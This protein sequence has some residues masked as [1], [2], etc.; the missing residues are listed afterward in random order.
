MG[1]NNETTTKFKADISNLKAGITQA[2]S[3][4]KSANAE[5]KNATAGMNNW[6]KSADGL[7]AKITQLDKTFS[8]Q[9]EIVKNLKKQYQLVCQQE[10]E[11]SASAQQLADKINNA[12][13]KLKNTE[14]QL[15]KYKDALAK[16]QTP[17]AELTT[18]IDT[19]AKNLENLK[20][21]YADVVIKEGENSESAKDLAGKI[22]SLSGELKENKEKLQDAKTKAEELDQSFDNA[23]DAA[24]ESAQ[25]SKDAA[26][27]GYTTMKDVLAD[28]ASTAIKE[29]IGGFKDMVSAA[30][31]AYS[32]TDAAVDVIVRKTGATGDALTEYKD[33]YNKVMS[34]VK[35]D[36]EDAGAAVGEIATRFKITDTDKLAA[37]SEAFIKFADIN[38]L[39]V[40]TA[41]IDVAKAMKSANVKTENYSDML[42]L[43]TK[44]GQETGISV[45]TLT[46]QIITNGATLRK[47]GF[48]TETTVA[49]L[50]NMEDQGLDVSSM[51][52]GFKTATKTWTKEGKNANKELKSLAKR[53]TNS[54]TSAKATTEAMTLFGK[55]GTA[56][57]EAMKNGK[58]SVEDMTETLSKSKGTVKDTYEEIEDA[59]DKIAIKVQHVKSKVGTSIS[60]FINEHEKEIGGFLDD[61]TGS[62]DGFLN[63]YGDDIIGFAEKMGDGFSSGFNW[64]VNHGDFVTTTLDTLGTIIVTK[65]A[66]STVKNIASGVGGFFSSLKNFDADAIGTAIS[67]VAGVATAVWNVGRNSLLSKY[68]LD[69]LTENF[70]KNHE[71]FEGFKNVVE[72]TAQK[73][74]ETATYESTLK[75]KLL[76]LIDPMG[77]VKEGHEKEAQA[78]ANELNEEL[79]ANIKIRDG[80]VED[81]EKT[82]KLIDVLIEKKRAETLL[83]GNEEAYKKAL[84]N[85]LSSYDAWQKAK[86]DVAKMLADA[87]EYA[88]DFGKKGST[89][90]NLRFKQYTSLILGDEYD[91]AVEKMNTL[92]EEYKQYISTIELYENAM[93]ASTEKNYDLMNVYLSGLSSG[94]KTA[95]VAT[96]EELKEQKDGFKATYDKMLADSK[97]G[98]QEITQSQLDAAYDRYQ[99]AS[100]Q[101]DASIKQTKDKTLEEI[102]GCKNTIDANIPAIAASSDNVSMAAVNKVIGNSSKMKPAGVKYGVNFVDGFNSQQDDAKNAG[103]NV[104]KSTYYA[105]ADTIAGKYNLSDV[106]RDAIAGYLR[107]IESGGPK[108][109]AAAA[110]LGVTTLT[111]IRQSLD[112][113]SPSRKMAKIAKYTIS[114]YVNELV[115]KRSEVAEAAKSIAKTVLDE[116]DNDIDFKGSLGFDLESLDNIKRSMQNDSM[117]AN[118][119]QQPNT[120]PKGDTNYYITQNNNS[121]KALN[122]TEIY[123]QTKNALAYVKN[124]R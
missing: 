63:E 19:Q 1:K 98:E 15:A 114:G 122:E 111:G 113:H 102:M 25:K 53:L 83:E 118:Y 116:F 28:L 72:N 104:V 59:G 39:D 78:L 73:V 93:S 43:L 100:M 16:T 96:T 95:K 88:N 94:I 21:K 60:D 12:E 41:V 70:E 76:E 61:I 77:K 120:Q 108:A 18:K 36:A 87:D 74:D 124:K 75:D 29:V 37:M 24:E 65:F 14:S 119:K 85:Q 84:E 69:E 106:A 112:I 97:S 58:L 105:M 92:G 103:V 26:N 90:Y 55:S 42:D 2:N 30:K 89:L 51:L 4:I 66:Y 20:D 81:L 9:E 10:G 68:G 80:E 110:Q 49:L 17:T 109:A 6:S 7:E 52:A 48:D 13:A 34:S 56:V 71:K 107:E 67:L 32:E 46:N 117:Q 115:N 40:N 8:A 62:F 23:G 11:N 50:A 86:E 54:K 38:D 82:I 57:V 27:G 101:Y 91:D 3:L 64:I 35:T 22:S 5:F 45:S 79:G 121:P 99:A 33:A 31:E 123:R 44:A 47:M